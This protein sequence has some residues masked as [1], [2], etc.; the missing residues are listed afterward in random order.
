MSKR[1]PK[2]KAYVAYHEAG[3]AVASRRFGFPT[4][5]VTITPREG[6][7]GMHTGESPARRMGFDYADQDSPPEVFEAMEELAVIL[8]AGPAAQ[9]RFQPR[10]WH[11]DHGDDDEAQAYRLVEQLIQPTKEENDHKWS[12][13]REEMRRRQKVFPRPHRLRRTASSWRFKQRDERENAKRA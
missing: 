11:D 4:D 7:M 6:F 3:H 2:L 5:S 8:Y 9:K 1:A 12:K 13:V 10:S